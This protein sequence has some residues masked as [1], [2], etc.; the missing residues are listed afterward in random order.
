MVSHG[1][2]LYFLSYV[3][4]YIKLP[5]V[6]VCQLLYYSKSIITQDMKWWKFSLLATCQQSKKWWTVALPN[7]L[8]IWGHCSLIH[9]AMEVCLSET[10]E[11]MIIPVVRRNWNA[12]WCPR[13]SIA[14]LLPASF[15]YR[16]FIKQ[17]ILKLVFG[18][19]PKFLR[20]FYSL[21]KTLIVTWTRTIWT[22]KPTVQQ[23]IV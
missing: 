13:N 19:R 7:S 2:I 17:N 23:K 5:N 10:K 21:G 14:E 3:I 12:L 15:A 18:T 9:F 22:I 11:V 20:T 8:H 16:Y 4:S 1:E 6:C